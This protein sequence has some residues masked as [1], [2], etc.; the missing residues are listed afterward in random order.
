MRPEPSA[1][2]PAAS[3]TP[4]RILVAST[5]HLGDLVLATSVLPALKS[6]HPEAEIGFLCGGWNQPLAEG[7]PLVAS[8]HSIDHWLQN[9]GG[10][11]LVRKFVRYLRM[12]RRAIADIR[13]AGN[14]R[15]VDFFCR[16]A[17]QYPIVI[18]TTPCGV[19]IQHSE[20]A[21]AQ[22]PYAPA[23][24][25][26]AFGRIADNIARIGALSNEQRGEACALIMKTARSNVFL[27]GCKAAQPMHM[28][29][30]QQTPTI[31]HESFSDPLRA[32]LVRSLS[33]LS[34]AVPRFF[35]NGTSQ[36]GRMLRLKRSR[37]KFLTIF[38][39]ATPLPYI[40]CCIK[41]RRAD[42]MCLRPRPAAV[43]RIRLNYNS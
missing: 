17:A 7:H 22:E 15:D 23:A 16:C 24:H 19:L 38:S 20:G 35:L 42:S 1:G 33:V 11:S 28:E 4:R 13:A 8:V 27:Q 40:H 43:A 9:R 18:S 2:D 39:Q 3:R 29:Q 32:A 12:R 6:A 25:W 5:A 30:A 31:L 41:H 26:P 37:N 21:S 14:P 34:P 10:E 36:G